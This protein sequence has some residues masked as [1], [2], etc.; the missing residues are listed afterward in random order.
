MRRL[1][2]PLHAADGALYLVQGE[3]DCVIRD[4]TPEV[5]AVVDALRDGRPAAGG[6]EV[7]AALEALDLLEPEAAGPPLDPDDAE[8]FDR[9]LLYLRQVGTGVELQRRL[10]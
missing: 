7:V 2:E 3:G 6:E 4:P 10:R 9:Q 8:R 5:R 1:V